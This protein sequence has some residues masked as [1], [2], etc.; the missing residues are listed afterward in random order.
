MGLVEQNVLQDKT[1][2]VL[3]ELNQNYQ[4]N[5]H[6]TFTKQVKQVLEIPKPEE[7]AKSIKRNRES[8]GRD[9]HRKVF[10]VAKRNEFQI[11]I[12]CD[13][14]L[15]GFCFLTQNLFLSAK[16]LLMKISESTGGGIFKFFKTSWEKH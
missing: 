6:T 1:K 11:I 10:Q 7:I 15:I 16:F 8:V 2:A 5:Y 4:K 3:N 13:G 12:F 14:F 9:M